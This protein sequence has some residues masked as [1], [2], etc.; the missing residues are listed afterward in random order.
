[1]DFPEQVNSFGM[2]VGDMDDESLYLY[3]GNFI[4]DQLMGNNS[5]ESYNYG[6]FTIWI[7]E[8]YGVA[9]IN[10]ISVNG[11]D[12]FIKRCIDVVIG[13][14]DSMYDNV[15][16]VVN[17]LPTSYMLNIHRPNSSYY[18][19]DVLGM[20][21]AIQGDNDI[22]T[23][24][25]EFNST[26]IAQYWA[27]CSSLLYTYEWSPLYNESLNPDVTRDGKFVTIV[28]TTPIEPTPTA[29]Q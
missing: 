5:T 24:I 21:S 19:Y 9:V 13:K 1:M 2:L 22:E 3:E 27:G 18:P 16:D 7:Y 4:L 15:K 28:T 11:H 26:E 29:G 23:A 10:N 8:Y 20:S 12:R 14:A 17:R 6:G 25:Y